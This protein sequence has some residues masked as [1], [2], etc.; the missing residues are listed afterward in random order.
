M[1][2][3][4]ISLKFGRYLDDI[5]NAKFIT[6]AEFHRKCLSQDLH[7]LIRNW[8]EIRSCSVGLV[9]IWSD[10]IWS[11]LIWSDL[12]WSDLIWNW[13]DKLF[14]WSGLDAGESVGFGQIS[15]PLRLGLKLTSKSGFSNFAHI[16]IFC[17]FLRFVW[18]NWIDPTSRIPPVLRLPLRKSPIS[19]RHISFIH[20]QHCFCPTW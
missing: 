2:F 13:R 18:K 17:L 12:I 3:W 9:W 6:K 7:I 19:P 14:S 4:A 1:N 20:A 10:L 15:P 11:D 5:Q 8:D 16:L